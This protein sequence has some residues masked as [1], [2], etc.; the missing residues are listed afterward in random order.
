MK[1]TPKVKTRAKCPPTVAPIVSVFETVLVLRTCNADMTSYGGFKWP[2]SGPV[3]CLDWSPTPVCGRGLHGL[4]WGEG[5]GSLVSF[6]PGA[7]GL[8]VRV[9][10]ESIVDL[11]RKVK[12]P[13]G[14][15]EFCGDLKGAADYISANGGAG[16]AI[17]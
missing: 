7:K 11:Q 15:V 3:K 16:R 13:A 10:L 17:V 1:K 9:Q 5:D 14:V 4:L 12:F 8:A 6:D 2:E